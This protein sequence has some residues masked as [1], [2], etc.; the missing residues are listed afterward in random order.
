MDTQRHAT[1]V[2]IVTGAGSGVGLAT[3]VRLAREGATLVTSDINAAGLDEA[4]RLIAAAG[5]EAT[6]ILAD[7]GLQA[8]VDRLV[9]ESMRLNGRVDILVNNAGINDNFLPAHAVDDAT[10]DRVMMVNVRGPLML[11]RRVLPGMVERRAWSGW[12][13]GSMGCGC[14][15]SAAAGVSGSRSCSGGSAPRTSRPSTSTRRWSPWPAFA[16]PATGRIG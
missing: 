5:A 9:A 1:K 7:I 10:W 8:D 6:G 11:C 3:A 2:A 4:L 16:S 13:G 12:A 15:K 14:S